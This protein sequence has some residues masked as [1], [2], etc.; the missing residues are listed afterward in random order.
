MPDSLGI[1]G[2]GK[3]A[4]AL[5]QGIN[6]SPKQTFST[7]YCSDIDIKRTNLFEAEFGALPVAPQQLVQKSSLVL[8]AVK[9]QQVWQVLEQL[10]DYWVKGT[11]LVSIAAGIKTTD[12]EKAVADFIPVVRVMPNTPC[13]VGSGVCAVTGGNRAVTKDL[14]LVA[15]LLSTVGSTLIM[16][17]KY[18]DAVTAV[19]GSGPA[20]VFLV[21]EAFINAAVNIGL[22]P[23][24]SKKLI[25][26]TFRGSIELMEKTGEHPAQLREQVCSPAGTTIAGVRKLEEG[27]VR[28]AFYDAV[29]FAYKRSIELGQSE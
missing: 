12:L 15:E 16:E 14:E 9:P 24:T 26:D 29:E 17:E 10:K 19:S 5:L 4:Y 2:C 7:I 1:I 8:L 11:V 23:L 13:L 18:M 6:K 25:L 21:L 28:Q 20:Y 3:M 22:D 27:G